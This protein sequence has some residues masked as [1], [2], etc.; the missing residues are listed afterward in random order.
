[1]GLSEDLTKL[2]QDSKRCKRILYPYN[3]ELVQKL[4][5]DMTS[6]YCSFKAKSEDKD[7]NEI[8]A[9]IGS[10]H[11][12]IKRSSGYQIQNEGSSVPI[13]S[14]SQ[15]A[16]DTSTANYTQTQTSASQFSIKNQIENMHMEYMVEGAAISRIKRAINIY[17]NSRIQTLQEFIWKTGHLPTNER[18]DFSSSLARVRPVARSDSMPLELKRLISNPKKALNNNG[19]SKLKASL[20]LGQKRSS[21][22]EEAEIRNKRSKSI[23]EMRSMPP[24]ISDNLSAG[25]KRFGMDYQNL[26]R[27]LSNKFPNLDLMGPMKPPKSVY[28]QIKCLKDCGSIITESGEINLKKN[29]ILYV[30]KTDVDHLL[31]NGDVEKY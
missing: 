22:D 12:G 14:S 23:Q 27:K 30:K 13:S 6:I 31:K 10:S 11:V 17:H 7:A 15:A 20:A 28:M 18:N 8:E 21:I 1:M 5:N 9:E 16:P 25:E 29:S 26:I 4:K 19:G 2:M 24:K 3:S